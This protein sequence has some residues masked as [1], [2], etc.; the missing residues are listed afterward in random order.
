MKKQGEDMNLVSLW[1]NKPILA[2][3]VLVWDIENIPIKAL[4]HIKHLAKFTPQTRYV[5]SKD[6]LC[7]EQ[8]ALIS[9]EGFTHDSSYPYA[10]DTKIVHLI[11]TH[12]SSSYL[13]FISSDGDFIPVINRFLK[14]HPVQWIMQDCNKKRICMNINLAHPNLTLSSIDIVDERKSNNAKKRHKPAFYAPT[15]TSFHNEAY[16]LR[17]FARYHA[18][19]G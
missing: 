16:W 3:S 2:N 10:T 18:H 12:H 6:T 11:D 9:K 4:P 19:I 1:N 8:E 5:I 14:K 7:D 15:F 13:M 17:Y